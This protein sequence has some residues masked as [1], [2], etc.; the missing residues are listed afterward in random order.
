MTDPDTLLPLTDGRHFKVSEFACH[1]EAKT[2]YPPEWADRWEV[3]VSLCDR[4]R[5]AWGRPLAVVSGYRTPDHNA[6]LVALDDAAGSHQVASGSYHVQG[7]AADLRP[8][9]A[10]EVPQLLALVL[11]LY[12]NGE[13]PELGGTADYPVSCWVHVDC[14]KAPDQHLRRWVGR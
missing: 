1:D 4:I 12:E 8:E 9:T 13:L 11:K 2:P 6:A 10:D 7:M 5:D 14:G 3:L